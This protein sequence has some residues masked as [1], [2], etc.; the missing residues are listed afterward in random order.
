[1]RRTQNESFTHFQLVFWTF[2][3]KSKLLAEGHWKCSVFFSPSWPPPINLPMSPD[4]TR[5]P[6]ASGWPGCSPSTRRLFPASG[7]L[8]RGSTQDRGQAAQDRQH[9]H[10]EAAWKNHGESALVRAA[11]LQKL[12]TELL[13][14]SC[15]G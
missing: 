8:T 14:D 1:M 15:L 12:E 13:L 3:L 6:Q 10:S 2:A 5:T 9:L 11:I 7:G 4:P